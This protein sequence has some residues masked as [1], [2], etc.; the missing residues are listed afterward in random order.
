M[1]ADTL[2]SPEQRGVR[3][4]SFTLHNL[5]NGEINKS[6]GSSPGRTTDHL[7]SASRAVCQSLHEYCGRECERRRIVDVE[8][9]NKYQSRISS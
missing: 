3:S 6:V 8:L 2:P 1:T 4:G 5:A 7:L 9:L